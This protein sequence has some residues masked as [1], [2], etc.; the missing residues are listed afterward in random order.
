MAERRDLNSSSSDGPVAGRPI[1]L[2]SAVARFLDN[3]RIARGLSRNTLRAYSSDLRELV[4][5]LERQDVRT[6]RS[7]RRDDVL[8]HLTE[9][10]RRLKKSTV[11]R[12]VSAIRELFAF[13]M[14]A[15]WRRGSNPAAGINLPR[16]ESEGTRFLTA[17]GGSADPSR[18][19]PFDAAGS[20]QCCHSRSSLRRWTSCC[21]DCAAETDR[22]RSREGGPARGHETRSLGHSADRFPVVSVVRIPVLGTAWPATGAHR[23][24]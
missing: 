20:A 2:R 17:G 9:L 18:T 1:L 23:P 22:R 12:R 14:E 13:A 4:A 16:A 8:V 19:G 6:I 21:R 15:G 7:V 3:A 5:G 11:A 24:A 10:A